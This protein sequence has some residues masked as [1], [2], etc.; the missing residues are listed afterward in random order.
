MNE[1]VQPTTKL[2]PSPIL[3]F[4]DKNQDMVCVLLKGR[5]LCLIA[6]EK[7][8]SILELKYLYSEQMGYDK[9]DLSFHYFGPNVMETVGVINTS[10]Y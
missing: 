10:A 7:F 8:I 2:I 6:A 4:N 1:F 5:P 3:S 9:K